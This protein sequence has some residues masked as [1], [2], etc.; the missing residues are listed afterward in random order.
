LTLS[1]FPDAPNVHISQQVGRLWRNLSNDFREVYAKEA[2]RLQSLHSL[3]F[4]DYKYQPRRRL[5]TLDG[6]EVDCHPSPLCSASNPPSSNINVVNSYF[7]ELLQNGRPKSQPK[8]SFPSEFGS[9]ERT[10]F[11]DGLLDFTVLRYNPNMDTLTSPQS[12]NGERSIMKYQPEDSNVY[13]PAFNYPA[14]TDSAANRLSWLDARS[15]EPFGLPT[16]TQVT[17]TGSS[18]LQPENIFPSN[19][20]WYQYHKE[21][22]F[23]DPLPLP[24]IETW[25]FSGSTI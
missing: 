11:T 24:G 16:Q 13:Q 7:D 21:G 14:I 19:E 18:F 23:G 9:K 1:S 4:P 2:R 20:H 3:E 22:S 17:F 10:N 12:I 6:D 15:I 25:T 5:R 8:P